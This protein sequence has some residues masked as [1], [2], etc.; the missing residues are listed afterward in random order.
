MKQIQ[1]MRNLESKL[2]SLRYIISDEINEFIIALKK[3]YSEFNL[4]KV[5]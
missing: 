3:I 1:E 2:V 4:K 5:E